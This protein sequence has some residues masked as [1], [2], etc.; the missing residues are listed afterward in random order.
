MSRPSQPPPVSLARESDGESSSLVT[1]RRSGD[2]VSA[3]TVVVVFV[4]LAWI[5]LRN[6][7]DSFPFHAASS[8][9]D[10]V[11]A[12][13]GPSQGKAEVTLSGPTS[14]V[15]GGRLTMNVS[16]KNV[17]AKSLTMESGL[18]IDLLIA[19]DGHVVS[20][21]TGDVAGVGWV[22]ILAPGKSAA[23]DAGVDVTD[24]TDPGTPLP[25]GR[26]AVFA[27][28]DDLPIDGSYRGVLVSQPYQ[29]TVTD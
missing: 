10:T 18:P 2:A 11:P 26:Y 21:Y 8:M 24:C 22:P 1:R 19:T 29:I 15:A 9:C 16:V 3:C 25:A 13:S 27:I 14:V 17:S 28:V 12:S 20:R 5:V 4:V 23:R 7:S 6:S